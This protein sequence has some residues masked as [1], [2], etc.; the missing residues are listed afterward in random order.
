MD[1]NEELKLLK[2]CKKGQGWGIRSGGQGGYEQNIQVL[3]KM[4]KK[5]GVGR[6]RS[7]GRGLVGGEGVGW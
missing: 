4:Q 1:V 2:K 6:G 5:V 7:G 3:V